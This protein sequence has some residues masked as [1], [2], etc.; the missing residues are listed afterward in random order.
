MYNRA[1][2]G[3][4]RPMAG[5]AVG[6]RPPTSGAEQQAAAPPP[7]PPPMMDRHYVRKP[8]DRTLPERVEQ[9]VPEGQL[10]RQLQE[11]ERRLDATISRKKLDLQDSLARSIKKTEVLRV[12]ISNTATDQPWQTMSKID[13]TTFDFDTNA[14]PTWNLRIEGRLVDDT[15]ADTPGRR[16]FSSFFTSIIVELENEDSE[17]P[18]EDKVVEWHEPPPGTGNNAEFD[19]LDI[20]RKGD[21]NIN[22]KI[23]L[24]LKEYPNKFKLSPPLAK[25]LALDEETKPGVVVALWQYI[26]FHRLQDLDEKRLI[27]CD[28]PMREVFERDTIPFPQI[29]EL[30]NP[31]LTQREPIVLNYPIRVD[32]ESTL[33]DFTYDIDLEVSDPVRGQ[34]SEVL[35]HWNARQPEI[36]QL[37]EEI[38][39]CI[40]ALGA[41]RLK[42]DF[43]HQLSLDP[44][45]FIKKWI[46]S[47]ARD[48]RVIQSDR[49]FNE[50]DVRHSSFYNEELLSQSIHYFVNTRNN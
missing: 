5:P 3:G 41:S 45:D 16:C 39:L 35:E 8:T 10:Y 13:E 46:A 34:M 20:R 27:K 49:G 47:Q 19:V 18:P 33:G 25:L 14:V 38:A 26:R 50:E 9:I 42:R 28:G 44:A 12:F 32:K 17:A 30:L 48:L 24:Q 15:P 1:R 11:A 40:E 43:F 36:M 7:P 22:A 4:G 37:D 6:M 21:Q 29:M 23:T 31:H 2:S